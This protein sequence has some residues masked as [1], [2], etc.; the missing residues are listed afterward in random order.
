MLLILF[1]IMVLPLMMT[2][3]MMLGK[4]IDQD[5][6]HARPKPW[7]WRQRNKARHG[8]RHSIGEP[9]NPILAITTTRHQ[10]NNTTREPPDL[11]ANPIQDEMLMV[12]LT[13]LLRATSINPRRQQRRRQQRRRQGVM[14]KANPM[15]HQSIH[16]GLPSRLKRR[17]LWN[18]RERK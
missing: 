6:G 5:N 14:H 12:L 7:P 8:I 18:S 11:L 10:S 13:L 4:R 16:R 17:A 3:K 15:M 2:T 1:H 9:R